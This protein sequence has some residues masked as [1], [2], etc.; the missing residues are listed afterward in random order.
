MRS[1]GY[2]SVVR[3]EPDGGEAEPPHPG[4]SQMLAA[5]PP[6]QSTSDVSDVDQRILPNP[7]TPGFGGR[8]KR[9]LIARTHTA[10]RALIAWPISVRPSDHTAPGTRWASAMTAANARSIHSQ[11]A[12]EMISA[13]RS[14]IV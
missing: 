7:G 6:P 1:I 13:G 10:A 2:G 12:S 11:S 9:G 4:R 8:V 5:D 3:R 14:L